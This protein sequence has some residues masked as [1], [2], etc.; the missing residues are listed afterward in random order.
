L[1][2]IQ[3][4]ED[5]GVLELRGDVDFA[6]EAIRPEH[7]GQVGVQ[8][9]HGH[10][11]AVLQVFSEIDRGHAAPAKLPLDRVAPAEGGAEAVDSIGHGTPICDS[12]SPHGSGCL[13]HGRRV[14]A[15]LCPK[16]GVGRYEA[17]ID[18]RALVF[19]D[20]RRILVATCRQEQ[21]MSSFHRAIAGASLVMSLSASSLWSQ[22]PG[23]CEVKAT[24]RPAEVGCYLLDSMP[25]GHPPAN[26]SYW[27]IY[28]FPSLNEAKS[29]K[30]ANGVTVEALGRNWLFTIAP[31]DWRLAAGTQVA[32]IGPLLVTADRIYTAHYAQAT[33]RPGLRTL[34][35]RH[36]GPEAFYVLAGAQCVESPSG[37]QVTGRGQFATMAPRTWMQLSHSGS[38]TLRSIL[39]ILHESDQPLTDRSPQ[40]D[41][42]PKDLCAS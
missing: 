33:L 9:F 36:P 38:D 37:R 22:V 20:S 15:R 41:W 21:R 12:N 10:L 27:H 35:H 1:A 2:G 14:R 4:R 31:R 16:L 17:S 8:D 6:E 30:T 42:K 11:A 18:W 19:S 23:R 28:S 24:K 3:Q 26:P 25:I 5:V 29:F 7:R 13:L 39:L 32:V 34:V 40:E